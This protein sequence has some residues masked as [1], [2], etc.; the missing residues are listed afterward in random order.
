LRRF[1]RPVRNLL[2]VAAIPFAVWLGLFVFKSVALT[3]ILATLAALVST[4]FVTSARARNAF[5]G[6]FTVILCVGISELVLRMTSF[7]EDPAAAW[8]RGRE[9]NYSAQIFQQDWDLGYTSLPN[10]SAK[11]VVKRDGKPVYDVVYSFDAVGGRVGA[12]APTKDH[13]MV[14]AGDSFNFGEGLSNDDTLSSYLQSKSGT[15]LSVPNLALPGYGMHQVL[16]QLE[17]DAPA[18]H[19]APSFNW[20]VVS[21]VDNHI[22]RVNGRYSWSA[23]GPE[24][25]IDETGT[26]RLIGKFGERQQPEWM[27]LLHNGS[28]FYDVLELLAGKFGNSQD[29]RRFVAIMRAMREVTERKY[30]ARL[31]VLYHPGIA[32][33]NDF[34]GRK[35]LM[36][37]LLGDAGVTYVDVNDAIPGIDA[38]YFIPGDGHPAAKLNAALADLVLKITTQ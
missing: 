32:F 19:G 37:R 25:A 1:I 4:V 30:K 36:H 38:S 9:Q 7:A 16:R 22:E 35:A 15:H 3:L 33:F 24:Y 29:E 26:L 31:L 14:I 10:T 11:V 27:R 5:L 6:L 21:L 20:L 17:L 28:R 34:V 8:A 2:A 13:A 23:G 18:R 12:W